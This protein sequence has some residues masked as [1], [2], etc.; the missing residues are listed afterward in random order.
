MAKMG[1]MSSGAH[2]NYWVAIAGVAAV[3]LIGQLVGAAVALRAYQA[4]TRGTGISLILASVAGMAVSVLG[5]I[6][7]SVG[8]AAGAVVLAVVAGAMAPGVNRLLVKFQGRPKRGGGGQ[9]KLG[10]LRAVAMWLQVFL[11]AAVYASQGVV[12]FFSF[13]SL[14]SGK[15]SVSPVVTT[16][17]EV[18]VVALAPLLLALTEEIRRQLK[19]SRNTRQ[20]EQPNPPPTEPVISS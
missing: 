17:I 1:G 9:A 7:K 5:V 20:P 18:A 4:L 2:D 15:D 6:T 11:G 19:P 16:W 10:R 3:L 12:L 8:G 13:D 14:A